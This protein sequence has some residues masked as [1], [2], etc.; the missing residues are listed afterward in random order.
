M[1]SW[2]KYFAEFLGTL[3][4][5]FF[6][7]GIAM[8]SS[9]SIG[10]LAAKVLLISLGF[11][12]TLMACIYTI[13]DVSGC[14]IN[15][16]VSIAMLVDG[17]MTIGEFIGYVISQF[18]GGIVGAGA[19]AL[20][21]RNNPTALGANAFGAGFSLVGDVFVLGAIVIE[22]ILTFLFV[23]TVLNVSAKTEFKG[24]GLVIGLALAVVHMLGVPFTGTSVNPARSFGPA[25][26][27]TIITGESAYLAQ[28]WVFLVAPLVGGVIAAL[29]YRLLNKN[30]DY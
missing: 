3:I 30:Y 20:I 2:K 4:L 14:H 16:A 19:L 13:G 21:V 10:N 8:F 24:A 5:V 22:I 26:F 25:M 23:Y 12:L 1:K 17:R 27:S 15:P 7:C 28:Y 18:L 29:V 6:A 9:G 11:G